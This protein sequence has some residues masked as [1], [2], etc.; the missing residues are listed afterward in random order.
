[1]DKWKKVTPEQFSTMLS[2]AGIEDGAVNSV[3]RFMDCDF[4][5]LAGV[6]DKQILDSNKGFQDLFALFALLTK[7]GLSDFVR[8]DPAIIRGFDYSDGLVYEVFDKNPENSRSL[9][10]GERFDKLIQIFSESYE[11]E[12]TGFAMGDITL[13]EFLRGWNLLPEFAEAA[14]VY[15]SLFDEQF[16]D[17]TLE[18][19]S[20]LRDH[21]LNVSTALAAEKLDKQFKYADRHGIP[22]VIIIGPDEHAQSKVTLKKLKTGEQLTDSLENIINLLAS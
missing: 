4:E 6:I 3:M 1:M 9:F 14:Q 13:E 18:T 8:F 7:N 17:Q 16:R 5:E 15:V 2:E 21:G 20:I 12:A 11:L 19:A 10:G 22:Y